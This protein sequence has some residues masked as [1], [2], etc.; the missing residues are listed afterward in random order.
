MDYI[1]SGQDLLGLLG[2]QPQTKE[3]FAFKEDLKA[4]PFLMYT[5][6]RLVLIANINAS[7]FR[8]HFTFLKLKMI[9]IWTPL[10]YSFGW[11]IY[12]YS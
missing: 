12:W 10:F 11:P 1:E 7:F 2:I 5:N 4:R 3:K 6:L 9:L 8:A